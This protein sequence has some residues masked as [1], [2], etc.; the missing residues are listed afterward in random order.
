MVISTLQTSTI[1]FAQESKLTLVDKEDGY[2][3]GIVS[4]GISRDNI[5]AQAEIKIKG[6]SG[7][8]DKVYSASD[9]GDKTDK[10]NIHVWTGLKGKYNNNDSNIWNS[11][12]SGCYNRFDGRYD[13]NTVYIPKNV[14]K[15]NQDI[16]VEVT[17][18]NALYKR[19]VVWS[20]EFNKY[21]EGP[22]IYVTPKVTL[23][24]F[25][26]VL[27]WYRKEGLR[28]E[29]D[30][31]ALVLSN[32]F[33]SG[34]FACNIEGYQAKFEFYDKDGKSIDLNHVTVV[35]KDG[36]T[37]EK[38]S[39]CDI[40]FASLND[41]TYDFEPPME[42]RE[43][44]AVMSPNEGTKAYAYKDSN[45][46]TKKFKSVTGDSKLDSKDYI[47][48]LKWN[49]YYDK[50]DLVSYLGISEN[51]TDQL[52][53]SDF[54]KNMVSF[55]MSE[56]D[57]YEFFISEFQVPKDPEAD[58]TKKYGHA[59]T[60]FSIGSAE[61]YI[62]EYTNTPTKSVSDEDEKDSPGNYIDSKDEEMI[63]KVN[64]TVKDLHSEVSEVYSKYSIEDALPNEVEF[65][66]AE[67]LVDG[68]PFESSAKPVYDKGTHKVTW[69]A[70][71]EDLGCID[72]EG[73]F[74]TGN[75]ALA[76]ETYTLLIRVKVKA[77]AIESGKDF[78]NTGKVN[79]DDQS[80]TSNEVVTHP[81]KDIE[82]PHKDIV[83]QEG[84]DKVN[85]E[86]EKEFSYNLSENIPETIA[87]FKNFGFKDELDSRLEYITDSAKLM[88]DGQ[89]L[90]KADSKITFEELKN[91]LTATIDDEDV[92][93]ALE[94]KDKLELKFDVKIKVS[95]ESDK[96]ISNT[97]KLDYT[98]KSG[99]TGEK[100]TNPVVV[101]PPGDPIKPDDPTK[102]VNGKPSDNAN[103]GQEVTFNLKEKLPSD[104]EE[105]KLF[106][107]K[108]VLD[109]KLD[110]VANSAKMMLD[111]KE[112]SGFK[113]KY[114]SSSRTLTAIA[115][116][117]AVKALKG[118]KELV[119]TFKAKLNEKAK[120]ESEVKNQGKLD[121]TNKNGVT[122]EKD[123]NPV[124]V[125]P[126]GDPNKPSDPSKPS[127]P[128]KPSD[129]TTP[130]PPKT[131]GTTTGDDGKGPSTS[132]KTGDYTD[133][134]RMY[135][136]VIISVLGVA[137]CTFYLKRRNKKEN[138]VK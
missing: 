32:D 6:M 85:Q 113:I 108:D 115:K 14:Y 55:K 5:N 103:I 104:I 8:P 48:D 26:N 7:N 92:L 121:Y 62:N 91:T 23:S 1:A 30:G 54:Y 128:E 127:D 98:N 13:G 56:L 133:I 73:K 16:N 17:Y 64:H 42:V 110:Y 136:I 122:G 67:M 130:T 80:M 65:V 38:D 20:E 53:S 102:D 21:V 132:P 66:S 70:N 82:D 99:V 118:G 88:V 59:W 87:A 75:M 123:T 79:F 78:K 77:E 120:G 71:K 124:V 138:D 2:K 34:V 49:D 4:V 10:S 90:N 27:E 24:G 29:Y 86:K 117:D 137:G 50:L 11:L 47:A 43:G 18:P 107:F 68:K 95:A 119:L 101:V 89:E 69:E 35:N 45:I 9:L 72:A 36:S 25:I 57:K 76:G 97:G 60:A 3:N 63:Y 39:I 41:R 93:K 31:M 83:G 19:S 100:D 15:Q 131:P 134:K 37:E 22:R 40:V 28:P 33:A 112:V 81:H 84:K 51:F 46:G 44:V 58:T 129:P 105:Y 114:D 94:G 109:E 135:A 74:V 125:V 96:E 52:G 126:P 116:D 61:K 12:T 111:G 106:G